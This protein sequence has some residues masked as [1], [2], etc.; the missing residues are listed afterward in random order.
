MDATLIGVGIGR[1]AY[2]VLMPSLI[3]NGWFSQSDAA[4]L[5]VAT[6]IGYIAGAPVASMLLR[7]FSAGRVIRGAM[8]VSYLGCA[9]QEASL[10]WFYFWRTLAGITEALFMVIAPP[11]ILPTITHIQ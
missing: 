7:Y 4:Y 5:G 2:I 6:L 1:F 8:L 9:L 10:E 11:I 3:Q